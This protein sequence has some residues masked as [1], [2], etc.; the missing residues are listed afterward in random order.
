MVQQSDMMF[1]PGEFVE[2]AVIGGKA[3]LLA[4]NVR[5]LRQ[6]A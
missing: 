3:G 4:L 2:F 1:S 5:S 6:V